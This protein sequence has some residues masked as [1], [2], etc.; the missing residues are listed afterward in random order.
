MRVTESMMSGAYLNDLNRNLSKIARYQEQLSTNKRI[1]RPSDDPVGIIGSL[2]VRS[3]QRTLAQH[4]RNVDDALGWLEQSENALMDIS[5]ISSRTYELA[6][7]SANGTLGETEKKAVASELAQLRDY[8]V[9]LGNTR[10]GDQY[11]FGGFNTTTPPFAKSG[12][13]VL[14][15]G[16]SLAFGAAADLDDLQSQTLRFEI[17]SGT[18]VS[19]GLNGID[20]MGRGEDSIFAMMDSLIGDLQSNAGSAVLSGHAGRFQTSQENILTL[21]ADIGGRANRLNLLRDRFS[22]DGY[23]YEKLQ[24]SIEDIDTA[25]IITRLKLAETVYEAALSIGS[26][27][28]LPN[29]TDFLR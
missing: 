21:A 24:S 15:Q 20:L 5:E 19:V 14:Y 16:V 28:I 23:N 26:K 13:D 18:L 10:L 4:S 6:L 27:V 29:L 22:E 3:S 7:Q 2:A 17:N 1:N 11:I 9:E 12:S 8:L 25:E